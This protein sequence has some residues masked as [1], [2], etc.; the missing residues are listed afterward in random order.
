MRHAD[1]FD[2]VHRTPELLEDAEQI[3]RGEIVAAAR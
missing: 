2:A 1:L 3:G